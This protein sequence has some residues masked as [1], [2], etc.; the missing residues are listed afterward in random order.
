MN[1]LTSLFFVTVA[2]VS[3]L[4]AAPAASAQPRAPVRGVPMD[5]SKLTVY[6]FEDDPLAAGIVPKG[7]K[8]RIR[9]RAARETVLRPRTSFVV[10]LVRSVEDIGGPYQRRVTGRLSRP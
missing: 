10:R 9:D 1:R 6:Q 7:P 4:A 8:L 3:I 5:Q 2:A